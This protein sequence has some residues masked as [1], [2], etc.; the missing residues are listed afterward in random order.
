M[1]IW[2]DSEERVEVAGTKIL[3]LNSKDLTLQKIKLQDFHM[4]DISLL[5][6]STNNMDLLPMPENKEC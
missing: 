2:G 3:I 1:Q 4:V 6:P 5:A